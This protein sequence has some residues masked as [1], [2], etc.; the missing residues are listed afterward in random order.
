MKLVTEV[1]VDIFKK[2]RLLVIFYDTILYSSSHVWRI[3]ISISSFYVTK[4][5]VVYL[6]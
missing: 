4:Q 3:F 2:I 6:L 5:D 1:V